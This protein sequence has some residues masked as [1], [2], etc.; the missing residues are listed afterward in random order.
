[1]KVYLNGKFVNEAEAKVGA[2]DAGVQHGVGLFETMQAFHGRVFRVEAHVER[3]IESAKQLGLTVT[4]HAGPLAELI[5]RTVAENVLREARIRLTITGGDLSLLGAAKS[6]GEAPPHTPTVLCQAGP[7]TEYPPAFFE[8]GVMVVVADAKANPFDP[9]AGHK[10][11]NYWSRLRELAGA[12]RRQ[13]GEAIWFT[14]SNHLAGGS[15]SNIFLVKDDQLQTPIARGEEVEGALPA[16]VLPGITRAAI[17]ELADELDVPVEKRMLTIHDLL[18]ADEVFLTNSSWQV[19]PVVRVEKE[20][21]GSGKVGPLTARL[22]KRLLDRIAGET[23]PP[24]ESSRSPKG[25]DPSN[26]P[27][28]DA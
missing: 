13:A 3:L 10:T 24:P 4:M 28:A 27:G 9:M 11:L 26:G 23:A 2:F 20:K 19:L 15:V 21:I 7:P 18:E 1:M 17:V 12:A 8:Q 5:E 22:R 14:V 6:G 16:P 25:S